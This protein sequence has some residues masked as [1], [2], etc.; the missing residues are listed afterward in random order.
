[1]SASDRL[2]FACSGYNTVLT[3]LWPFKAS[4]S[5]ATLAK[6]QAIRKVANPIC[7]QR[8]VAAVGQLEALTIQLINIR[9]RGA[10]L[11]KQR[12]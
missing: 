12:L 6:I 2:Y 3:E 1:M 7:G 9:R 4:M 10:W 8:L 11:L 5:L